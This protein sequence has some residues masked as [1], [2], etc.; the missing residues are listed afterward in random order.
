M[1]ADAR[2]GSSTGKTSLS[3]I[4]E[5]FFAPEHQLGWVGG[6]FFK[7]NL[8]GDRTRCLDDAKILKHSK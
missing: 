2:A 6:G 3:N 5:R 1:E 7:V 8:S 4:R